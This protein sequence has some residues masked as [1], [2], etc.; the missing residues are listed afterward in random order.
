[1]SKVKTMANNWF[2]PGC[3]RCHGLRPELRPG[4]SGI[5]ATIRNWPDQEVGGGLDEFQTW[6]RLRAFRNREWALGPDLQQ[7]ELP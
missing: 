6:K 3:K 2:G 5:M 1:M 7:P 4:V